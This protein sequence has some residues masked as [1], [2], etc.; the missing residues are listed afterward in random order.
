[1]SV[2]NYP[3]WLH[4]ENTYTFSFSSSQRADLHIN[5]PTLWPVNDRELRIL[6]VNVP[7]LTKEY[8]ELN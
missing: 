6:L 1:M 7:L 3:T 8:S 2:S 5:Y 4:L